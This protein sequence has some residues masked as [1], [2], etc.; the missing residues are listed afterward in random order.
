MSRK[1]LID[2]AHINEIRVAVVKNGLLEDLDFQSSKKKST[3]G[4]IYLAKITRV[5]PSLQAA[6]V[7]YGGNRHGFLPFAE[8]H[9]DYYQIPVSDREKI[10]EE[11]KAY[12]NST[13]SSQTLPTK[14]SSKH[15]S[16]ANKVEDGQDSENDDDQDSIISINLANTEMNEDDTVERPDF[17][18]KYRIQEVAKKDQVILVQIEKEER[19][20]KGA[21]LTTFISIAGRFCVLMPNATK[22]GGVSRKISDSDD[23]ER[24]KALAKEMT[25]DL[26][27]NGAVIIRTAGASKSK[28]E[29][30][31]DCNYLIKMWDNIRAHTMK[32]NAPTFIHEEG[33][34]IKKAIRD[35]YDSDI[36]EIVVQGSQAF[37]EAKEFMQMIL[38]KNSVKLTNYNHKNSIFTKYSI[39]QQIAE[40]YSTKVSLKSGGY[41]IINQ[42]EALVAIDVNSGRATAERN[43]ES[44][45]YKTNLEAAHEVARQLRLRDLSGLVVID[46]IDMDDNKNKR[47]IEKTLRDALTYDKAK[48]QIGKIS[49]FGLLELSRQRIKQSFVESNTQIC[50]YCQG[51]SRIRQPEASALAILR[52]IDNEMNNE[53]E[54]ITISASNQIISYLLNHKRHEISLMDAKFKGKLLFLIDE[55]AQG[56]GFFI[57][58]EKI[59]SD[60]TKQPLSKIDDETVVTESNADKASET[61]HNPKKNK[62]DHHK[63]NRL[64]HN[65]DDAKSE[66]TTATKATY[67][68]HT[69]KK[70]P[71]KHQ[72]MHKSE[73]HSDKTE[74]NTDYDVQP[75]TNENNKTWQ[76]HKHKWKKNR[77]TSNRGLEN[78][79]HLDRNSQ[80]HSNHKM[81]SDDFKMHN[82]DKESKDAEAFEN[83]M[84]ERRKA[85]QSL[86]K[87][88]WKKIVD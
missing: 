83:E 46:F 58:K 24:L 41:I 2:A 26:S 63:N 67:D 76:N 35:M 65:I 80:N 29:I 57:E 53:A 47:A 1:M 60:N 49:H 31:R 3:K 74:S 4:N 40:L 88:I 12:N 87:E 10:L 59:S 61:D 23:R 44:T 28:T 6:F 16:K 22:G 17:Y 55:S 38:P 5:E 18:N 36:E 66:T 27:G 43:V 9:P 14:K 72:S 79:D 78:R 20:N 73:R 19:G 8:I 84:A 75:K 37:K 56:D 81:V 68:K 13:N 34:V 71:N 82:H 62:L 51:R 69:S 86:L 7:E 15:A 64:N 30:K 45:A 25:Q 52:A 77:N 39:E 21:A 85:N 54:K 70:F 11:I 48:I 32:S 33:D 42:T 50:N